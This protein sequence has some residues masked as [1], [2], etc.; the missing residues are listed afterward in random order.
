MKA[1]RDLL[2]LPA[3]ARAEALASW[4]AAEPNEKDGPRALADALAAMAS[5]PHRAPGSNADTAQL[6]LLESEGICSV[7]DD[8]AEQ[9]SDPA[10]KAQLWTHAAWS[11][12]LTGQSADL[13]YCYA[14]RAVRADPASAPA[15]EAFAEAIRN[16]NTDFFDDLETFI[17]LA[18]AGKL[19]ADV[20][21]RALTAARSVCESWD[22]RD[23][24]RLSA[25]E[26]SARVS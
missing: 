2:P 24:A 13:P 23:L 19:P 14:K 21:Q 4:L 16:E 22:E 6:H 3:R 1:I 18:R 7:L 25:L 5:E 26:S 17:A 12:I 9:S 15:W 10:L 11:A 8:A 20:P